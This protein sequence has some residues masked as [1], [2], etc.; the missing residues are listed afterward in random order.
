VD[1]VLLVVLGMK[2]SEQEFLTAANDLVQQIRPM[3]AGV[4]VRRYQN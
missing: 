1:A 3:F 2:R 4:P